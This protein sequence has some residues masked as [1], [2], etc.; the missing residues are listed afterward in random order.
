VDRGQ[1]DSTRWRQ[2][3]PTWLSNVYYPKWFPDGRRLVFSA[4]ANDL[5]RIFIV[6]TETGMMRQLSSSGWINLASPEELDQQSENNEENWCDGQPDVW[7]GV[8]EPK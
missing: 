7:S 6:D 5:Y 4:E 2:L 8:A 3:T 1:P